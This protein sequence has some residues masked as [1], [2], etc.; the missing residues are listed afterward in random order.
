MTSGCEPA[1]VH[2][3]AEALDVRH[4][5]RHDRA[6]RADVLLVDERIEAT[7]ELRG[8]LGLEIAE[9]VRTNRAATLQLGPGERFE[10]FEVRLRHLRSPNSTA[11]LS[12]TP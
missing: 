3:T 4:L 6:V 5:A 12:G 2:D 8:D 9:V 1:R 11:R 7:R 10:R